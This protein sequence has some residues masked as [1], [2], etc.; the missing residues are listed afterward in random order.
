VL[1]HP[2]SLSLRPN[3]HLS[4]LLFN[5]PYVFTSEDEPTYFSQYTDWARGWTTGVRLPAG[6]GDFSLN[7]CV[8]TGSDAHPASYPMG[9]GVFSPGIKRPGHEADH[10][11]PSSA[12]IK[13]EWSY[14]SAHPYVFM[15]WCSVEHR[16][17]F[18]LP[19]H[20]CRIYSHE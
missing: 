4:S 5:I 19:Y 13:N 16:D 8:Q 12:E 15:V 3:T 11:P 10:S 6:A 2:L 18:T 1:S 20:R 9:T 17:K 7:Y 14:S